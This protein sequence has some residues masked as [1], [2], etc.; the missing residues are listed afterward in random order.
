MS[1]TILINNIITDKI[2]LDV[3]HIIEIA[4]P[5]SLLELNDENYIMLFFRL[6]LGDK[7]VARVPLYNYARLSLDK[8]LKYNWM[9]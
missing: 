7:I 1:H 5:I 2:Q 8:N 3:N 9:V 6:K 4:I